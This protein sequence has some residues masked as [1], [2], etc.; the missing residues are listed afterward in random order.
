MGAA[1]RL[2]D[3]RELA[4]SKDNLQ[5]AASSSASAGRASPPPAA[6][7][8]GDDVVLCGLPEARGLNGKNG[9]ALQTISDGRRV[10]RLEDGRELAF[11][12][13]NMQPAGKAAAPAAAPADVSAAL[14]QSKGE[15]VVLCGLPEARGLNGTKGVALQTISDGRRVVRLQDGRELAF[16][17]DN[18]QPA[19][20]A[21]P[22]PPAAA[23]AAAKPDQ[24]SAAAAKPVTPAPAAAAPPKAAPPAA[25]AFT[26]V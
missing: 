6:S 2:E 14:A 22:A 16:S 15:D 21:S 19:A 10:V 7:P 12:K 26:F 20:S 4:F 8:S 18:I 23:P 5:P 13:D 1:F 3:G 17:K 11:S 25:A 9:V 24:A